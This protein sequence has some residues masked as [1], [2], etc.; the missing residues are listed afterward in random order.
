MLTSRCLLPRGN[1]A[2]PC[3]CRSTERARPTNVPHEG[4][5][6]DASDDIS[7]SGGLVA[8][9][10]LPARVH[11]VAPL[12]RAADAYQAMAE[13]GVRGRIVLVP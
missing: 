2:L 11:A 4:V 8:A 13:G 5:G 1:R 6:D 12:D 3:W 10:E 7:A 9:G